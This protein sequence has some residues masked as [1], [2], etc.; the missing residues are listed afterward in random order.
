MHSIQEI[1]G[2]GLIVGEV[3]RFHVDDDVL[4]ADAPP[5]VDFARLHAVARVGG[6]GYLRG[7]EVIRR[8]RLRPEEIG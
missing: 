7:G 1:H 4:V 6:D 3:V 8:R 5:E 2:V